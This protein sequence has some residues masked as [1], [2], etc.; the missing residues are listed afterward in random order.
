M[1]YDQKQNNSFLNNWVN[2]E[3]FTEVQGPGNKTLQLSLWERPG[4]HSEPQ[5]QTQQDAKAA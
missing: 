3:T 4:V 5:A 1:P 2:I